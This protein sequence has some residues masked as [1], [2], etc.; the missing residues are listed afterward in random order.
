MCLFYVIFFKKKEKKYSM[1]S[2]L[3]KKKEYRFV[4][5]QIV[6]K[7]T[8]S[9]AIWVIFQFNYLRRLNVVVLIASH[10]SDSRYGSQLSVLRIS[11]K[12]C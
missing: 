1:D 7:C 3:F 8:T 4:L 9:N 11:N 2:S 10:V 6:F 5:Q 12:K